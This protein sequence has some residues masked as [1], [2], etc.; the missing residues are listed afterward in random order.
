MSAS[1]LPADPA[2]KR[3]PRGLGPGGPGN[4]IR[5]PRVRNPGGRHP[6]ARRPGARALRILGL[7]PA[8]L[9][10]ALVLEAVS[11]CNRK[12]P[13]N[14]VV[15]K[16]QARYGVYCGS[17]HSIDPARDGTLGP[18]IK[19]SSLELLKARVIHGTY[20]PGYTPKRETRI[21]Q[22]LPLTET[23]VEAIHAYLN[24]P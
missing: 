5:H 6:G 18:A 10:L 3:G 8:A 11:A 2:G 20:P 7:L 12:E 21:M 22:R 13:A 23:D 17:C 24:A 14:P 4:G 16:G 1:P 15:A 9:L 19:G